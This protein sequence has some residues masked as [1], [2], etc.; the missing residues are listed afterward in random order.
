MNTIYIVKLGSNNLMSILEWGFKNKNDAIMFRDQL[1]FERKI[2]ASS[3]PSTIREMN[4]F[5]SYPE[6]EITAK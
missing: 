2:G 3:M 1:D 5:E 4:Y 6:K